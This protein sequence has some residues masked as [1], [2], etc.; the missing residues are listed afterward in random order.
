MAT[1]TRGEVRIESIEP[2]RKN[3]NWSRV[4]FVQETE[5]RG[6]NSASPNG[7][8]LQSLLGAPLKSERHCSE[9]VENAVLDANGL[10]E[11]SVV[12]GVN[13]GW[14]R[15]TKPCWDGHQVGGDGKYYTSKIVAEG[16]PTETDVPVEVTETTYREWKAAKVAQS[17]GIST[18]A[19][20]APVAD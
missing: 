3:A 2:S 5:Y 20:S 10:K 19:P 12:K 17:A 16:Q 15:H 1:T 8:G 13:I 7:L 4:R 9:N 11:G 14:F 6:D 18:P